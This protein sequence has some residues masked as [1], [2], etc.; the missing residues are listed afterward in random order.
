L[1]LSLGALA[2]CAVGDD[3]PATESGDTSAGSN[4]IPMGQAVEPTLA[5]RVRRESEGRNLERLEAR[6]LSAREMLKARRLLLAELR[7]SDLEK[8][9]I[10]EIIAESEAAR[11]EMVDFLSSQE[12]KSGQTLREVLMRLEHDA[13][14]RGQAFRKAKPQFVRDRVQASLGRRGVDAYVDALNALS[15]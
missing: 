12:M 13:G 15:R 11:L 2:A 9:Q 10:G 1:V 7:L 8:Q 3:V 4:L 14:A 5:A 6:A